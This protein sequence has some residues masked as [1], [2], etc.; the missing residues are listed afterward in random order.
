MFLTGRTNLAGDVNRYKPGYAPLMLKGT[1]PTS[2]SS[3]ICNISF[4][5]K[6][7]NK[8]YREKH[9]RRQEYAVK[10]TPEADETFNLRKCAT[11]FSIPVEDR[12]PTTRPSKRTE[13]T[14]GGPPWTNFGSEG[15]IPTSIRTPR[16]VFCMSKKSL[17]FPCESKYEVIPEL[18][19]I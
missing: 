6:F 12:E 3:G 4:K 14:S 17:I 10:Q 5:W 13:S 15:D 16:I 2:R 8:S 11:T 7:R 9:N 18:H 19:E 1:Y